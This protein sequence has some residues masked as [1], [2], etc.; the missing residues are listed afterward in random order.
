MI[1]HNLLVGLHFFFY[2]YLKKNFQTKKNSNS[3]IFK[4]LIQSSVDFCQKKI[5]I[6]LIV[7][8]I[9]RFFFLSLLGELFINFF[10]NCFLT[11]V[12]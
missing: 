2:S 7:I 12:P 8:V 1:S 6:V 11:F 10:L 9:C 3:D 5:L 4:K